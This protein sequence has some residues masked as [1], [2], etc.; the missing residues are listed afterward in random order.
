MTRLFCSLRGIALLAVL[1]GGA[2]PVDAAT[3][4]APEGVTDISAVS[5]KHQVIVRISTHTVPISPSDTAAAHGGNSSGC[6]FS[7]APCSL[8]DSLT[9]TV[10]GRALF[11]ARSVFADLADLQTATVR[12]QN[13]QF[14]LVLQGGDAS[15]SYSVDISF[16]ADRVR[17]R[18]VSDYDGR[19]LLQ[20]TIYYKPPVLDN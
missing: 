10:D 7:R 11:V 16:D 3:T 20:K 6:T 12:Q 15:E 9:L 18:T 1:I 14:V 8:V 5:A 13:K 2:N 19:D 17:Q 4:I